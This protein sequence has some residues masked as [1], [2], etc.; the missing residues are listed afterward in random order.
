M[1]IQDPP[2]ALGKAAESG[3]TFDPNT[4]KEY[5]K[6]GNI[7]S[8]TVWRPLILHENGPLLCKGT[9]Q[10][11]ATSKPSQRAKSA[12][13]RSTRQQPDYGY[14]QNRPTTTGAYGRGSHPVETNLDTVSRP[15]AH[16][17]GREQKKTDPKVDAMFNSTSR[18]TTASTRHERTD[19]SNTAYGTYNQKSPTDDGKQGN[20][21]L[22]PEE[23]GV[24]AEKYRVIYGMGPKVLHTKSGYILIYYDGKVYTQ[25]EWDL[26]NSSFMGTNTGSSY[27]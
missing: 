3:E 15:S 2:V 18:G 20:Q 4:F 9:A 7:V 14:G 26:L 8:Y 22:R 13:E 5:T 25:N 10:P 23:I 17:D 19:Y 11:I 1:V 21:R 6:T 16:Y 24:S 27:T 12:V